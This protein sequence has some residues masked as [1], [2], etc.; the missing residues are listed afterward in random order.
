[1]CPV[2]PGDPE[3]PQWD[4]PQAAARPLLEY[5]N[6]G[7]SPHEVTAPSGQSLTLTRPDLNGDGLVDLAYTLTDSSA[8][9]VVTP[10]TMFV[11]LCSQGQYEL[12]YSSAS[13]SE[14]SAPEVISS[15]DLNDDGRQEL[16]ISQRRC[17][18]HTCTA[19]VKFLL[20]EEENLANRLEGNTDDLPSPQI[21]IRDR[22]EGPA[23]IA[24]TASGIN[25]S[26]AGP[27]RPFTRIWTW[28]QTAEIYRPTGEERGQT[29]YRIHALHDADRA[30]LR[31]DFAEASTGYLRVIRDDSL[32]GWMD[33]DQEHQVLAAYA[34]YRL[35]TTA[36]QAGDRAQAEQRF[37][38][39]QSAVS[40]ESP[41]QSFLHLADAFW[42]TYLQ[43]ESLDQSCQSAQAY[44]ASHR[45]E[46]LDPLYFGY[47]N[48]AYTPEDVCPLRGE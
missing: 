37:Q 34:R 10:G 1:A 18:A 41:G 4:E 17:G 30:A 38:E 13:S 14:L 45:T 47:A 6:E 32:E 26:G 46:V 21:R 22:A 24:I 33:P 5:L 44:A 12:I 8:E 20:L 40:Q 2:Q 16:L 36:I 15:E 19:E 31:N 39:L 43:T 9:S 48:P 3:A 23:Q 7:G 11:Y 25:S 35:V 42:T 29:E 28:D 27:F